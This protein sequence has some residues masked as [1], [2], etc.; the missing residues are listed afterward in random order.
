LRRVDLREHG[1]MFTLASALSIGLLPILV[2]GVYS[3]FPQWTQMILGNG[4]AA[5]TI[6]A[7]LVNAVFSH[8]GAGNQSA[9]TAPCL[10]STA[11]GANE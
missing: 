11:Q 9:E 6:T 4:L 3:Q 10:Q 2:P 5:G 1:A 7:V 8:H